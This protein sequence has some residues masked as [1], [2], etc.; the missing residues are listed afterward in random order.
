MPKLTIHDRKGNKVGTYNVE[1]TDF[2]PA[3]NKQL[4]HDAVVMYQ[5]NQRQGSHKT[6]TRAEVAGS[7]K[8]L[9]R[10]KGTGNA[11]AG[12]RRSGVRRGGGHIHAVRP[13]DYSYSLPRKALRLA[14][15]MAIAS[16]VQD[17]EMVVIDELSFESPKTRN[18][19]SIIKHLG[20]ENDSLLVATDGYNVNVYKSGRNIDRVAVAPAAELNALSVLSARRLLVTKSALDVLRASAGANGSSAESSAAE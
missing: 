17:D 4:L 14:T 9:Y 5:A 8:K 20:I 3:I 19:V 12:H 2:A 13:R 18:M 10:Q 15:R 7:T 1:P 11:R 16:K 6:K